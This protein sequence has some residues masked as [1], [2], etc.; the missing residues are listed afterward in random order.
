[1]G[2][3]GKLITEH[4]A[5]EFPSDIAKKHK[6]RYHIMQLPDNRYMINIASIRE[7]K[8]HFNILHDLQYV[9]KNEPIDVYGAILWEDGKIDRINLKTGECETVLSPL[10]ERIYGRKH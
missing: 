3:R 7:E 4:T 10:D 1:M 2:Y 8:E 6:D 9:L 5:I